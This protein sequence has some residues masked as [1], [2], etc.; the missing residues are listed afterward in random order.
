MF[1]DIRGYWMIGLVSLFI[2]I[3]MF[4]EI[5]EIMIVLYLLLV[6]WEIIFG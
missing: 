1:I 4:I 5:K 2:S 3:A 6:M